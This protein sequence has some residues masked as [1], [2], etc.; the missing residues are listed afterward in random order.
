VASFDWLVHS[1]AQADEAFGRRFPFAFLQDVRATFT[2]AHSE[3]EVRDAAAYA[4]NA[5]FSRVLSRKMEHYSNSTGADA[6][7]RVRDE[8]N[9]VKT[10]MARA[11]GGGVGGG[12]KFGGGAVCL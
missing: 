5:E 10:V 1:N 7:S 3:D 2:A 12:G 8:V 4:F 11:H 9:E 6:I